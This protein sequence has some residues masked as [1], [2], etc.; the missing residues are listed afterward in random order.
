[1]SR[2]SAEKVLAAA[3]EKSEEL[4]VK[5]LSPIVSYNIYGTYQKYIEYIWYQ[6]SRFSTIV[7]SKRLFWSLKPQGSLMP[8][9]SKYTIL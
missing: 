9:M 2:V 5:V 1:M 6:K 7:T 4:G 3:V 8:H